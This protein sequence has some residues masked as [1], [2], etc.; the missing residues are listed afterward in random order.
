M[1][2]GLQFLNAEMLPMIM[3]FLVVRA[4]RTNLRPGSRARLRVLETFEF[5]VLKY[6]FSQILRAP[7]TL[8][9]ERGTSSRQAYNLLAKREKICRVKQ[10]WKIFEF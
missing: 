4:K 6:A 7:F 5:L 10:G 8:I 2:G 3:D 9:G 1:K